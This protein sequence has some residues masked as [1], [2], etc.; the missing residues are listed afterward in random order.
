MGKEIAY[1]EDYVLPRERNTY[2]IVDDNF[3][4]KRLKEK[5]NSKEY[6]PI[7]IVTENGIIY[8]EVG[9]R[10]DNTLK[11]YIEALNTNRMR[12]SLL[13]SSY[14]DLFKIMDKYVK[15]LEPVLVA[16]YSL[17]RHKVG[18]FGYILANEPE[19]LKGRE[20]VP[21]PTPIFTFLLY[22]L[23]SLKR[24]DL[25]TLIENTNAERILIITPLAREHPKSFRILEQM[26]EEDISLD[27]AFSALIER[28]YEHPMWKA[29]IQ[30]L[31]EV[32]EKDPSTIEKSLEKLEK[33]HPIL[34]LLV[35]YTFILQLS[36]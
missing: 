4:P 25:E 26:Y 16:F 27:E 24:K 9:L 36:L 5:P 34:P 10:V 19:Y 13:K 21:L 31:S 1:A 28:K 11:Q 35:P 20:E 15:K 33:E 32:L 17:V 18:N 30:R 23:Y 6:V 2:V 3:L 12:Y 8:G 29:I 14:E 7:W 22:G